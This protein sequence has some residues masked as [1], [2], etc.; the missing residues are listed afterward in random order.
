[1]FSMPRTTMLTRLCK[2][3]LNEICIKMKVLHADFTEYPLSSWVVRTVLRK[4]TLLLATVRDSETC[5]TKTFLIFSSFS[6]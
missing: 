4:E 5:H 2:V 1:M 6:I 3:Q